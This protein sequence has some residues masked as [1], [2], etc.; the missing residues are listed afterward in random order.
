MFLQCSRSLGNTVSLN[1]LRSSTESVYTQTHRHRHTDTHTQTHR[2]TQT[3][4]RAAINKQ[5]HLNGKLHPRPGVPRLWTK[6][7]DGE[8]IHN[9]QYT[10]TTQFD[11]CSKRVVFYSAT[12]EQLDFGNMQ[13]TFWVGD[14]VDLH[15]GGA[16]P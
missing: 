12:L 10:H 4:T 6:A 8:A 7:K 15:T 9:K 1:A 3:H 5:Y 2:Q 16:G 13:L 11:V 14:E